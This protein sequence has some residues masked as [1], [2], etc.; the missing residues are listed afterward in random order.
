MF[1]E[2]KYKEYGIKNGDKVFIAKRNDETTDSKYY[3]ILNEYIA[4]F[5]G[6]AKGTV[7]LLAKFVE[8]PATGTLLLAYIAYIEDIEE[9][10]S[11]GFYGGI[12]CLVVKNDNYDEITKFIWDEKNREKIDEIRKK[13]RDNV[14]NNHTLN[15]RLEQ[16]KELFDKFKIN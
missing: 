13:G 4:G 6:V 2:K 14:I 10:N 1:Q 5:A 7:F 11:L 12:N 8:I 9:L 16:F 3:H 15:H